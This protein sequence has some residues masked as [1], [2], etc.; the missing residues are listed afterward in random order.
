MLELSSE[1]NGNPIIIGLTTDCSKMS[2]GT[3][4]NRLNKEDLEKID[5][6]NNILS[7]LKNNGIESRIYAIDA[8]DKKEIVLQLQDDQKTVY[9]GDGSDLNTRALYLKKILEN[10]VGHS[11]TIYVNGDLDESYVYFKEQ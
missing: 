2:I 7:S 6:I 5:I 3:S 11:G 4:K 9:I 10:E 8:S 1:N